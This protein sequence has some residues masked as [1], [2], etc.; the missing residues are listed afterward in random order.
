MT[1]TAKPSERETIKRAMDW[2]AKTPLKMGTKEFEDGIRALLR[3]TPG[4][5]MTPSI[6]KAID[7]EPQDGLLRRLLGIRSTLG[8]PWD[9]AYR[10]QVF[11]TSTEAIA[12]IV[13]LRANRRKDT[14]NE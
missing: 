13:R 2:A 7:A 12:E 6:Q 1:A 14:G 8:L 10:Q 11:D 3:G 4:P 9:E 5:G